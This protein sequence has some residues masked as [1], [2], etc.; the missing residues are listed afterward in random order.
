MAELAERR[1][2]KERDCELNHTVPYG[3]GPFL[4]KV[5]GNK[6]PGYDHLIPTEGVTKLVECSRGKSRENGKMNEISVPGKGEL[7]WGEVSQRSG[8][9]RLAQESVSTQ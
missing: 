8:G 7:F 1:G 9:S 4:D 6:L 2:V 5:P 3:T